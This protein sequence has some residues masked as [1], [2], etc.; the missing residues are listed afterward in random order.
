MEGAQTAIRGLKKTVVEQWCQRENKI[1]IMCEWHIIYELHSHSFWVLATKGK[2]KHMHRS[3][4]VKTAASCALPGVPMQMSLIIQRSSTTAWSMNNGQPCLLTKSLYPSAEGLIETWVPSIA[5]C[6]WGTRCALE[7]RRE[8]SCALS[9]PGRLIYLC[10]IV[11]RMALHR[12]VA[13]LLAPNVSPTILYSAH[14]AS[15]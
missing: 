9:T 12:C 4:V 3:E 14:L 11:V 13:V 8:I 1:T 10:I 15:L 2:Q 7:L 6:T 5:P